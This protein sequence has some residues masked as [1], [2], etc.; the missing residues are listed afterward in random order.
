MKFQ[1]IQTWS[2]IRIHISSQPLVMLV[3]TRAECFI[4]GTCKYDHADFLVVAAIIHCLKHFKIGFRSECIVDFR[5]I[6]RYFCDAVIAFKKNI[7]IFFY[8]FPL[9][10][11]IA[12]YFSILHLLTIYFYICARTLLHLSQH[13]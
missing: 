5:A 9:N 13:L 3:T 11:H 8:C 1:Y 2:A 10:I 7:F 4:A 6:D 12:L